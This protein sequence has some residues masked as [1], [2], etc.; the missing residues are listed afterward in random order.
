MRRAES[1]QLSP[2]VTGNAWA[3]LELQDERTVGK[4]CYRYHTAG[5]PGM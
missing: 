3:G 4:L 2:V 5:K 1:E